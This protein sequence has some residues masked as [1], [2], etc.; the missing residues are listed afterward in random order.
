MTRPMVWLRS[1]YKLQQNY[2]IL[3]VAL[4]LCQNHLSDTQVIV[5]AIS[6][7]FGK[8]HYIGA[9]CFGYTQIAICLKA[10]AIFKNFLM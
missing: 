3:L 7:R 2:D 8:R 5:S 9:V 10:V 4:V 1:L 6:P